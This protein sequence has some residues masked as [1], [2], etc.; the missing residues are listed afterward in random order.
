MLARIWRNWDLHTL[1]VR[2]SNEFFAFNSLVESG[3]STP[4]LETK[5]LAVRGLTRYTQ[6]CVQ[7]RDVCSE[8]HHSQ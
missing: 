4:R 5:R 6:M 1:P 3:N 7:S 8:Q 2:M